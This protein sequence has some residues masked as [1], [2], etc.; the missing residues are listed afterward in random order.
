M[1][2]ITPIIKIVL[3]L[4]SA[5]LT[6]FVIPYIKSKTTSA[7]QEEINAWVKIAVTAAEQ[8]YKGQG[9]GEEKKKYVIEWLATKGIKVDENELDAMIEAAVYELTN[10]PIPVENVTITPAKTNI[11]VASNSENHTETSN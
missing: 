11:L 10:D 2:D 9:R 1:Y 6:I 5:I 8:L 4:I 3:T 7:Q